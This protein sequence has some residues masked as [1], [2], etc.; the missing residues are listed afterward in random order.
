MDQQPTR[1]SRGGA[2]SSVSGHAQPNL[3]LCM[4]LPGRDFLSDVHFLDL[5]KFW[6]FR[7]R[8]SRQL[9]VAVNRTSTACMHCAGTCDL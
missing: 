3:L 6:P 4:I 1:I 2:K 7:A 9:G 5:V 8:R